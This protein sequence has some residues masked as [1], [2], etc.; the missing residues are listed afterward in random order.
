MCDPAI[1]KEFHI[2]S[3]TKEKFRPLLNWKEEIIYKILFS[4]EE[5]N[6]EHLKFRQLLADGPSDLLDFVLLTLR[7][8]KPFDPRKVYLL[9]FLFDLQVSMMHKSTMHVSTMNISM[10]QDP[11]RVA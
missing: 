3:A 2:N 8:L 5:E 4:P 1:R 9:V 6:I 11:D 7:A 10:I